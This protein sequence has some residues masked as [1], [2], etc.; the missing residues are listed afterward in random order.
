L[1]GGV[2]AGGVLTHLDRQILV[3]AALADP[4]TNIEVERCSTYEQAYAVLLKGLPRRAGDQYWTSGA[5]DS[6]IAAQ[7]AQHHAG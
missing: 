7:L 1:F 4:H 2:P 3:I 5:A 6:F